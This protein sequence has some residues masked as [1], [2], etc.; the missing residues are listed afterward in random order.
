MTNILGFGTYGQVRLA[1]D[2]E[3]DRF[4]MLF[5]KDRC[6]IVVKTVNLNIY[7]EDKAELMN[8]S[9]IIELVLMCSLRHP[10]IMQMFH[11]EISGLS[12]NI[13]MPHG[14]I[15]LHSWI[16]KYFVEMKTFRSLSRQI[17]SGLNFMHSNG[18]VHRDLRPENILVDE[19][20]KVRIIDFGLS[21][22]I[23]TSNKH[24]EIN[25]QTPGY[26]AP[27]ILSLNSY[28]D[29]KIDIWSLGIICLNMLGYEHRGTLPDE[30]ELQ[31]QK[32][33][34]KQPRW[35]L[36]TER[37][38]EDTLK[39]LLM[40][41]LTI[42]PEKRIN[43]QNILD[44]EYMEGCKS[45]RI[46]NFCS[47]TNKI[48]L[49]KIERKHNLTNN[50]PSL[51]DM[52]IIYDWT[53][54]FVS[55]FGI[56]Y[57]AL[58]SSWQLLNDYFNCKKLPRSKFQLYTCVCLALMN[59]FVDDDSNISAEDFVMVSGEDFTAEAIIEAEKEVFK[60]LILNVVSP[61]AMDYIKLFYKDN[62]DEYQKA[63]QLVTISGFN[64]IYHKY[65][66]SVI[67]E[68]VIHILEEDKLKEGK[69]EERKNKNRCSSDII[70]NIKLIL[71]EKIKLQS[72]MPNRAFLQQFVQINDN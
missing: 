41:M 49:K 27:E 33:M 60:L 28:Y 12:C 72:Y 58:I 23:S 15:S 24:L 18:Y 3:N 7:S 31:Y 38:L 43:A 29:Y 39:D 59:K 51:I 67:A 42:E 56:S 21:K 11:Y 4:D 32:N 16:G 64:Q 5:G 69:L 26:K 25:V 44:H 55:S 71:A 70:N 53:S 13:F 9:V 65:Q 20:Q 62:S 10:N 8:D 45:R 68:S 22:Y 63:G 54:S 34:F 40:Q 17:T 14:G 1:N 30:E 52:N 66:P 2:I 46:G 6:K 37:Y 57:N 47:Y 61:S 35:E 50:H 36:M 48:Q 19:K